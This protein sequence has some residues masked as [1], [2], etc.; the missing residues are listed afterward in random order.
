M[1][2]S[3]TDPPLAFVGNR[4]STSSTI[5]VVWPIMRTTLQDPIEFCLLHVSLGSPLFVFKNTE[6]ETSDHKRK[7]FVKGYVLGTCVESE[8]L[9]NI[10]E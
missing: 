8:Q 3:Q 6:K 10:R 7:K 1:L 5:N 2:L 4:P 9:Q